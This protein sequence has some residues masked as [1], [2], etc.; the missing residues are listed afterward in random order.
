MS[1][2][3]STSVSGLLAFQRALDVTSNN[4]ANAATPGYSVERINLAEQPSQS[5]PGGFIGNGVEVVGVQRSYDEALAQQ[6]R[7]SQSGY[8]GFNAFATQAAQVD[9][10]LS[11]SSTGLTAGLQAFVNAMQNVASSPASTAQRQVL[12][13][14]AQALTQ[15]LQ[16]YDSRLTQYDSNIESQ[17][18]SSVSQINSLAT[19]IAQLNQ[20]IAAAV[21]GTGQQPN[22]MLDQRD[23]LIDQL[24]QYVSVSTATQSDGEM[25]VYIGTGQALVAAGTAQ[26]LTTIPSPYDST[27]LDVGLD[28]GGSNTADITAQITGGS[29]GGLLSAR[30]QVIDATRN[31]LGR[32][33]VG[34]ATIVNGQQS[35]GMDLTGSLGQ[36]MFAVGGVQ[37]LAASTNAGSASLTVTRTSLSAL[38]T[39]N[40]Q[41]QDVS[42]TWKLT[43][44][45]TDQ[46]VA[47]SGSGTGASPF[48]AAGLSIVV[49]GAATSGDSF[50]IEPTAAATQGLSVLISSPAQI[51]AASPLQTGAGAGNAGTGSI[52]AATVTDPTNGQLL[53]TATIRFTSPTTYTING[54]ASQT[55]TSGQPIGANGWSV[56]IT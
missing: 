35:V 4:V 19:N 41:M 27:R 20:Q 47:M 40:Y 16:S 7:S 56:T 38:T 18:G 15:Q 33:S 10:M 11:D 42:G 5:S 54:G 28:Q 36:P 43:D 52:S 26:T 17:I 23:Q 22:D 8:S 31:A 14:Q 53:S 21:G 49:S 6:V 29:L 1:D 37:A 13:S 2:L 45:T 51:A 55:Y 12:L 50:E 32:V 39:D 46:A 44:L 3:L 34:L 24:S 30:S 48:T 25:N 9:N